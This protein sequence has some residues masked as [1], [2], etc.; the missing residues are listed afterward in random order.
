MITIVYI[1]AIS[2]FIIFLIMVY[3][4]AVI[5][6]YNDAMR[7]ARRRDII[8]RR[9]N[10]YKMHNRNNDYRAEYRDAYPFHR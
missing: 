5:P 8:E 3:F 1:T 2:L 10:S 9:I 7:K 6:A 4:T